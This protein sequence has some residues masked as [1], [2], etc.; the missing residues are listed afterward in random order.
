MRHRADR[1]GRGEARVARKLELH[2]VSVA[3]ADGFG[4]R[5]GRHEPDPRAADAPPL[6][7]LPLSVVLGLAALSVPALFHRGLLPRD[8]GRGSDQG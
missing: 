5:D 3:E 8:S 4:R 1:A 2:R 7:D 6:P